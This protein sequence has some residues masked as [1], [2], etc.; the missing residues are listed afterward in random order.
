MG[1]IADMMLEGMLCEGCGI[2]LAGPAP[3]YPRYCKHCTRDRHPYAPIGAKVKCHRCGKRVKKAFLDNHMKDA[4]GQGN[5]N[6]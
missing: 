5:G 1:S 4:H 6:G 3:G 2:S